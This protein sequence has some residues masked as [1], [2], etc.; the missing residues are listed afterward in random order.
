MKY[1]FFS[2]VTLWLVY[3]C[4]THLEAFSIG[5]AAYSAKNQPFPPFSCSHTV[6]HFQLAIVTTTTTKRLIH[7]LN[8]V[9]LKTS[10]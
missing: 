4:S 7:V 6:H 2:M 9:S 8:N 10:F 1:A 3:W 5:L